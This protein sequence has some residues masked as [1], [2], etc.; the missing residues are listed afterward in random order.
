[1]DSY[2]RT[3]SLL[4]VAR[5]AKLRAEERLRAARAKVRWHEQSLRRAHE[6]QD[7]AVALLAQTTEYVRKLEN[8]A[9]PDTAPDGT[10]APG[11]SA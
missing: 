8:Q 5:A 6:M 3:A 2:D 11:A 7:E 4:R 1:M 10:P 9:A